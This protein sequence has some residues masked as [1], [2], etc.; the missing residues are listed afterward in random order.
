MLVA[1]R[2]FTVESMEE[3]GRLTLTLLAVLPTYFFK[4]DV[5]S[6]KGDSNFTAGRYS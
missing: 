5:K 1:L 6:F 4:W 3:D 2:L